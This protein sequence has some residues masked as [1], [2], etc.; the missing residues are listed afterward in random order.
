MSNEH[1]E[2]G[3][4]VRNSRLLQAWA[5][6]L[7]MFMASEKSL[8]VAF[9]GIT[10]IRVF[11]P[12]NIEQGIMNVEVNRNEQAFLIRNSLFDIRHSNDDNLN[13]QYFTS[14]GN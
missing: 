1:Q 12:Q 11:E 6:P 7:L 14:Q 2:Q 10:L 13:W 4:K 9:R 5:T 3:A 8:F